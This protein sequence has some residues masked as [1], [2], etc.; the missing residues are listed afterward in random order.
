LLGLFFGLQFLS[1]WQYSFTN[2]GTN[3]MIEKILNMTIKTLIFGGIFGLV[4]AIDLI[5]Q[6][7]FLR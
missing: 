5:I 6:L 2:F 4:S 7:M 1:L 3:L